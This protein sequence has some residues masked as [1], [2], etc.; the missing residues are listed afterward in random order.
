MPFTTIRYLPGS[1]STCRGLKID[2]DKTYFLTRTMTSLKTHPRLKVLCHERPTSHPDQHYWV[3]SKYVHGIR[4]E[5][6]TD[7]QQNVARCQL[8][9]E[10]QNT[11]IIWLARLPSPIYRDYT[12]RG[13]RYILHLTH[14]VILIP[15]TD[16]EPISVSESDLQAASVLQEN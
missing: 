2:D 4:Y 9:F 1:W 5:E 13:K 14:D 11:G 12:Y 3:W 6:A 15:S 10:G 16:V 7:K 8:F